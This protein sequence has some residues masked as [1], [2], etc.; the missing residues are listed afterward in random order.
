MSNTE[1]QY[2]EP[3]VDALRPEQVVRLGLPA[4]IPPQTALA[5]ARRAAAMRD[6]DR[7]K[8]ICV[9][10]RNMQVTPATYAGR[11]GSSNVKKEG[12]KI[13]KI[14]EGVETDIC[15]EPVDMVSYGSRGAKYVKRWRLVGPTKPM[16]ITRG[17]PGGGTREVGFCELRDG[18]GENMLG[19]HG[20][21]YNCCVCA[22]NWDGSLPGEIIDHCTQ[23]TAG[24]FADDINFLQKLISLIQ[25]SSIE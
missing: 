25:R 23:P 2:E 13:A 7:L 15:E 4:A 3:T 9:I 8:E 17:F 11:R 18:L 16:E 19:V 5:I 24:W 21:R 12:M 14:L 10:L 22:D 1:M 6:V 20:N